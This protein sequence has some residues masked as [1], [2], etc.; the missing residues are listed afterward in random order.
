[1]FSLFG[2]LALVVAMVGLYSVLA[3]DV[4]RRT[5]ELGIRS[6]MGASS[7]RLVGMVLRGALSVTA[8]GVSLG[9]ILAFIASSHL[10]PLLFET[11]PRDP[12]VLIGASC[13]LLLVAV[14]AGTIPALVASRVD[15]MGALRAE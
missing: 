7:G 12:L 14:M 4:A 5:R 11:S 15:P 1:M 8:V 3:F 13:T 6:A 9:L 10:G 2:L